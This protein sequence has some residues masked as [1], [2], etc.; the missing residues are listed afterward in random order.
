MW[1][2]N[3]SKSQFTGLLILV[4]LSSSLAATLYMIILLMSRLVVNRHIWNWIVIKTCL[5]LFT[6]WYVCRKSTFIQL[7]H[8]FGKIYYYGANKD[9][10]Q[11]GR[12]NK[13][14]FMPF[15]I[16]SW[17]PEYKLHLHTSAPVGGK[18]GSYSFLMTTISVLKLSS[19]DVTITLCYAI[20]PTHSYCLVLVQIFKYIL[21]YHNVTGVLP[22]PV[23]SPPP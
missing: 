7:V 12:E 21:N 16:F 18:R 9:L 13:N 1:N 11:R 10:V 14:I 3:S 2:Y 17:T 15:I 8:T 23:G 22:S 4:W 19:Y 20:H 5:S 6:T